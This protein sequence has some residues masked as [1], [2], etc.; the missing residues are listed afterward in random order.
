LTKQILPKPS[1]TSTG[2]FDFSV[3]EGARERDRTSDP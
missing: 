3:N 2:S 1:L